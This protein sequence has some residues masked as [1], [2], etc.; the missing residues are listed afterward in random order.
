MVRSRRKTS[1]RFVLRV[2]E[3]YEVENE[4]IRSSLASIQTFSHIHELEIQGIIPAHHRMHLLPG[5]Y[6][7]AAIE[8]SFVRTPRF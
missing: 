6:N 4:G 2:F 8:H 5:N 1:V 3:V 7:I